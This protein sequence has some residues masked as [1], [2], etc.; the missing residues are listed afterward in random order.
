MGV[1]LFK[2]G[3]RLFSLQ[4]V[5]TSFFLLSSCGG[6]DEAAPEQPALRPTLPAE[7]AA[8]VRSITH[9]GHVIPCYDWEFSYVNGRLVTGKGIL[10]DPLA[11]IDRTFS[12]TNTLGYGPSSVSMS[13]SNN[14]AVKLQLNSAGYIDKMTV[15]RDTYEFNYLDGRL[16]RWNK[17]TFG[18]SLGQITQVV[19]GATLEYKNGDLSCIKYTKNQIEPITLTFET[20]DIVNRNG[21]LP[22]T[23]SEEMGCLGFEN[24]YYAGLLG[25]PTI[26]LVRSVTIENLHN[27]DKNR[28]TRFEY[29]TATGNTDLCTYHYDGQ[30]TSVNYL[31]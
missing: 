7:G 6:D 18:N 5:L 1:Q 24:L 26:H 30:P 15:N 14:E 17:I 8:P 20:S 4:M 28:T 3:I 31:Y 23:V 12:Y 10:R 13:T 2:T 22:E 11:S 16:V 27:P 25:R 29:S 9:W 21:L 19:S